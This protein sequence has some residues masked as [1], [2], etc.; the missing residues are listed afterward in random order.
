MIKKRNVF[1]KA[2]VLLVAAVMVLS[3]IPAVTADT[4]D[5]VDAAA[6]S[7]PEDLKIENSDPNAPNIAP[8]TV[9]GRTKLNTEEAFGDGAEG[10]ILFE[11]AVDGPDASWTFANIKE[12]D[13][14]GGYE[15][16]QLSADAPIGKLT[17]VGLPLV[18]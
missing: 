2:G 4:N 16:F 7:G 1:S 8:G 12:A 3:A 5:A 15:N 17:I 9:L 6:S 14:Y 13:D 18:Y 10:D 11:Q